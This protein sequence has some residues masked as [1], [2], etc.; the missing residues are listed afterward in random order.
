MKRGDAMMDEDVSEHTPKQ[1]VTTH[2][3]CIDLA[4]LKSPSP[5][6]LHLKSKSTI[7]SYANYLILC[8]RQLVVKWQ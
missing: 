7:T 2:E 1:E 4:I 3:H 8:L 5:I 6:D